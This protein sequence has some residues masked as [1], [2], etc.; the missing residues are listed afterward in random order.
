MAELLD[1]ATATHDQHLPIGRAGAGGVQFRCRAIGVRGP[2]VRKTHF[3]VV[4]PESG[5]FAPCQ[6]NSIALHGHQTS[7]YDDLSAPYVKMA[8]K[9]GLGMPGDDAVVAA[10]Y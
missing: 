6:A 5:R 2:G 8:A 3:R 4:T 7:M 9:F 10:D 1:P